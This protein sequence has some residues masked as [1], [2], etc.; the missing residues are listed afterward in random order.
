MQA[1]P[2]DLDAKQLLQPHVAQADLGPEVIQERKLARLVGS[3]EHDVSETESIG[4]AFG[5]VGVELAAGAEEADFVGA[6]PG[7]DDELPRSRSEPS[8]SLFDQAAHGL[9]VDRKSTR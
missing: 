4:E 5:E 1:A 2:V 9:R 6:L 3:L 7:L 8:V